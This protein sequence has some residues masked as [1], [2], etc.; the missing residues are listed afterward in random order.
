MAGKKWPK[1]RAGGMFSGML[2]GLQG[3]RKG[4]ELGKMADDFK[5]ACT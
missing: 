5:G 4:W 1:D 3:L 2:A